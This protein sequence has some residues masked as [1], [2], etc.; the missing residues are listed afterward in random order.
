MRWAVVAVAVLMTGCASQDTTNP[1]V[2]STYPLGPVTTTSVQDQAREAR[3]AP[4]APTT[5]GF[6]GW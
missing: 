4:A 5:S 2:E 3:P 6:T 1:P